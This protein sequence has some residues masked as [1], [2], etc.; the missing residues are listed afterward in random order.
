MNSIIIIVIGF[1]IVFVIGIILL[2]FVIFLN[3]S[4]SPIPSLSGLSKSEFLAKDITIAENTFIPL[5]TT[6]VN[7]Q[8]TTQPITLNTLNETQANVLTK[9]I[10]VEEKINNTEEATNKIPHNIHQIWL[11]TKPVPA[12][13]NV[14]K[15]LCEK[16]GYTYFLWREADILN[17][18]LANEKYYLAFLHGK[19]YQGAAD[20]ARYE[21][22]SRWG[23]IYTDADI[24][25][26][27]L[28]IFDYLPK[29]GFAIVPEH[30]PKQIN[31]PVG[32]VFFG[33]SFIVSAINHSI[34]QLIIKSLPLNYERFKQLNAID[35]QLVTGPY[36]LTSCVHGLYTVI[37]KRWILVDAAKNEKHFHL[38]EFHS[39]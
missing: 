16:Y 27:D 30:N 2:F 9:E 21:I 32:S 26:L 4:S 35:P 12:S 7:P 23:G 3:S 25:P 17:F 15:D 1:M 11:G 19:N 28:P 10:I 8:P 38:V 33:N 36:L 6:Q 34:L 37:D 20:V 13:I 22:L 31:L 5:P 24:H 14:W 29:E 18:H 39:Y